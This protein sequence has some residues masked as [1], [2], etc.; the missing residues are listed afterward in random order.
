VPRDGIRFEQELDGAGVRLAIVVARFNAQVT[1]R[2]YDG[3]R[4]ALAE[5]GVNLESVPTVEAPGAFEL[6]LIARTL[7]ASG[8]FDAIICLGAVIRGE[9]PH[10]D[11][12][13]AQAAQGIQRAALDTGVPVVFGV[14]TTDTEEQALARAGGSAGNK[15]AEAALTAIEMAHTL[16]QIRLAPDE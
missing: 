13:S 14:L 1:R 15:G 16:R 2:L 6:P 8:R 7:A 3:C 4:A 10:F 9:T 12:V 11:Y 5:H